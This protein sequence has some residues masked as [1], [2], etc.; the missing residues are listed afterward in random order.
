M[1]RTFFSYEQAKQLAR[2]A[3]EY[4]NQTRPHATRLPNGCNYLTPD[5]AHERSGPMIK[6]WSFAKRK[7]TKMQNPLIYKSA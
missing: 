6:K 2:E 3:I 4:Y 7:T 1:G 5:Q